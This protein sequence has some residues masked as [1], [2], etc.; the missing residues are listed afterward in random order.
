QLGEVLR[1]GGEV[2]AGGSP[3]HEHRGVVVLGRDLGAG[4]DDRGL[5]PLGQGRGKRH[6]VREEDLH[7]PT[8]VREGPDRS[9][10]LSACVLAASLPCPC[11]AGRGGT[12]RMRSARSPAARDG[13]RGAPPSWLR[14][15]RA[16]SSVPR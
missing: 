15:T 16:V 13:A 10:S 4:V 7:A 3:D 5:P 14:W 1:G 9:D 8:V 2:A 12:W 11:C 6:G